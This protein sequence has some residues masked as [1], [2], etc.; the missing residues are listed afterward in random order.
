MNPFAQA[1]AYTMAAV[2]GDAYVPT[3]W[4]GRAIDY[5]VVLANNDGVHFGKEAC[6]GSVPVFSHFCR[7]GSLP[8]FGAASDSR[9]A[10]EEGALF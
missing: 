9:M 7:K 8:V 10:M 5:G 3:C 4:K 2:E 1:G 6:G